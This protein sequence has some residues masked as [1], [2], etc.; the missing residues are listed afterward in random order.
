MAENPTLDPTGASAIST[1]DKPA[2][3]GRGSCHMIAG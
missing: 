3:R 1:N 2:R